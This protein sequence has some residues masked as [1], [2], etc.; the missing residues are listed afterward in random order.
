MWFQIAFD[1]LYEGF[2]YL[3][4]D[5]AQVMLEERGRNRNWIAGPLETP[6]GRVVNFQITV[7]TIDPI[8]ASL[9]AANWPYS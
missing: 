8:L 5:G 2:A 4:L 1:R 6:F 9:N 7:K 3:D